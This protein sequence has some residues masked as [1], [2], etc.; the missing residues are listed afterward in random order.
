MIRS[1]SP[2]Q[3]TGTLIVIP[4]ANYPAVA[5][6]TRVS[7]IDNGNLNRSYPG[8]ADAEPTRQAAHFISR[9]LL[10]R[11]DLVLDLHSGGSNSTYV[12]SMFLYRGPSQALWRRKVAAAR[13]MA[14]PYAVVVPPRLE[15]GSLSSAGD[16]AGILTLST[17][18][19]GGGTVDRA[20]LTQAQNGL[21]ALLVSEG[22][23]RPGHSPAD[24]GPERPGTI[25]IELVA[26]SAVTTT[27]GGLFEPL[28][29]PGEFVRA[30]TPVGRV[31]FLDELERPA[32]VF[33]AAV[34]GIVAIIR[35]PTFVRPGCHLVHVAPL[36]GE[37]QD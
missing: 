36:L 21:T 28:V 16:D 26:D 22:V 27:V 5:A 11:A 13:A 33:Q 2:D 12:P 14:L 4:S 1:T 35:H 29:D 7:P 3:L 37:P 24:P 30:G 6:G 10:P 15:P 8:E 17:E 20:V 9:S 25:W 34:D 23:L 18:P 32:A 31:H 19:G